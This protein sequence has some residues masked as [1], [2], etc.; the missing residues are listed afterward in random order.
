MYIEYQKSLCR[1]PICGEIVGFLEINNRLHCD[2]TSL[3]RH[4][5]N[6]RSG[7]KPNRIRCNNED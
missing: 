1:C 5:L 2:I 4:V 6:C 7:V 3:Q